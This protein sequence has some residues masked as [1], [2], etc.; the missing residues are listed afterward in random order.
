[1]QIIQ[2]HELDVGCYSPEDR[3]SINPAYPRLRNISGSVHNPR[4]LL[5]AV[6]EPRHIR[7]N[8]SR[9]KVNPILQ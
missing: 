5:P 1:M 2:Q 8:S 6:R 4:N 7:S 3:T 9:W